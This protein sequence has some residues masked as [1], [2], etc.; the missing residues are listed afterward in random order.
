MNLQ[1]F[2]KIVALGG[3]IC[4]AVACAPNAATQPT[5]VPT[6]AP[7][8]TTAPVANSGNPM[9]AASPCVGVKDPTTAPAPSATK[10]WTAPQQ[11]V[12]NTH[13]YC[14]IF[15]TTHGRIVAQLYPTYAPQN[16][17]NFVFLAQQ[18]FYDNI[19]FHRVLQ[20]FMAQSGDPTGTGTGGPGYG[21]I[22]LEPNPALNYD[23]EGVIGVARTNAPNSAGSQFFITFGPYPSLNQLYTI[24]GHVVEG[25]DVVKQIKLRD[26]DTNPNFP[27]DTLVSVRIVD[28]GAAK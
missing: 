10:Q 14:A 4:L 22:P 25:M 19:T 7:V 16:V 12:D 3:L 9:D 1:R 17:N 28:L 26:P 21:N 23:R 15:T 20:D 2:L 8:S 11:V 24:I 5:A 27:G 13:I 6:T 18:G